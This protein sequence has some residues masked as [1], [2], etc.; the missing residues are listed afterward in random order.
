MI[1][2]YF[3]SIAF[4]LL[5]VSGVAFK[6]VDELRE[7]FLIGLIPIINHLRQVLEV[8]SERLLVCLDMLRVYLVEL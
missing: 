7:V 3:A 2:T 5:A 6:L 1:A 4:N 8:A